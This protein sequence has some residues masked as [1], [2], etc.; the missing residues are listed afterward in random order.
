MVGLFKN[1]RRQDGFQTCFIYR[2]RNL[3]NMQ[4]NIRN[5]L[6]INGKSHRLFRFVGIQHLLRSSSV[7]CGY[8]LPS[9]NYCCNFHRDYVIFQMCLLQL[10]NVLYNITFGSIFRKLRPRCSC[11]RLFFQTAF[12]YLFGI[13]ITS[14][15]AW[16]KINLFQ[17]KSTCLC[18]IVYYKKVY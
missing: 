12:Q 17:G 8:A 1:L 10:R 18:I 4:T 2:G 14:L 6:R 11:Y 3:S 15:I 16:H 7:V 9:D 13:F 5:L